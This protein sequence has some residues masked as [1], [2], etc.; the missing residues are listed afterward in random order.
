MEENKWEIFVIKIRNVK[1]VIAIL[2][3]IPI[4]PKFLSLQTIIIVQ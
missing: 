4:P 1:W 2:E 3:Q